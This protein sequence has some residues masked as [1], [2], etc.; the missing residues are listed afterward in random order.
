MKV[1][2]S[3]K[4]PFQSSSYLTTKKRLCHAPAADKVLPMEFYSMAQSCCNNA[5]NLDTTFHL[6]SSLQTLTN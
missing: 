1:F 3:V 4:E 2:F 5:W 6:Q